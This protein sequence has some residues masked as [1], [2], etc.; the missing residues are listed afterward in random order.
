MTPILWLCSI[1]TIFNGKKLCCDRSV[2]TVE[3]NSKCLQIAICSTLPFVLLWYKAWLSS[4]IPQITFMNM[5]SLSHLILYHAIDPGP[6]RADGLSLKNKWGC[7]LCKL[8]Q[9]THNCLDTHPRLTPCTFWL[10][11]CSNQSDIIPTSGTVSKCPL[12]KRPVSLLKTP[13][14][15]SFSF[16]GV[17]QMKT[18]PGS[19][20]SAKRVRLNMWMKSTL[21]VPVERRGPP[22]R[23]ACQ[24]KTTN[25]CCV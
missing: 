12:A 23:I 7:P 21:L 19:N 24:W 14:G 20:A 6:Y 13:M 15:I 10:G 22:W 18:L 2:S 4:C 9:S 3:N 8:K 1:C 25:L 17:I 16:F 11:C 5:V